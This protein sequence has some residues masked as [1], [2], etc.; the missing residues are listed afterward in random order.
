MA[1]TPMSAERAEATQTQLR[2]QVKAPDQSLGNVSL[3]TDLHGSEFFQHG[4]FEYEVPPISYQ[5]GVQLEALRLRLDKL[6]DSEETDTDKLIQLNE[7]TA[8]LMSDAAGLFKKVVRPKFLPQ[9][10]LWR[11][12]GNPFAK[13]SGTDLMTLLYFFCACRMRSAV[14]LGSEKF[15]SNQDR[16]STMR[17]MT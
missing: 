5:V 7:Q 15:N 16:S 14:R 9:R 17:L 8:Q 13:M 12:L 4:I 3:A 10:L 6:A 1:L 2:Q 11:W